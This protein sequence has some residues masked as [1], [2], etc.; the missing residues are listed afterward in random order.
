[1]APKTKTAKKTSSK[2]AAPKTPKPPKIRETPKAPPKTQPEG[3]ANTNA[4]PAATNAVSNGNPYRV[5]SG[6]HV[7]FEVIR[8]NPPMTKAQ[9][10]EK[11]TA[12]MVKLGNGE[13]RVDFAFAVVTAKQHKSKRGDYQMTKDAEGLWHLVGGEPAKSAE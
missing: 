12:E 5:G 1:M 8:T 11:A 4:A 3:Q 13:Y 2:T 7:L 6:Y 9:I 10:L